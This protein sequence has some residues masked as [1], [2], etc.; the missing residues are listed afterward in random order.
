MIL[1]TGESPVSVY[2]QLCVSLI[3]AAG[4]AAACGEPENEPAPAGAASA[5][6]NAPA[7]ELIAGTPPGGLE[8]WVADIRSGTARIHE[9]AAVDGTQAQRSALDLYVG[10]QEYLELYYGSNGRLASEKAPA[11]GKAVLETESRFHELLVLLAGTPVDTAAVRAKRD[12]LHA[13]LDRV[14]AESKTAGIPLIPP[15][16]PPA[17][18][19]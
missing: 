12:E 11:L 17:Q 3:C 9:E 19:R 1:K 10:R 5:N 2:R 4:M 7:S 18:G 15:G 8:D 16:N 13:H 6:S 14:L